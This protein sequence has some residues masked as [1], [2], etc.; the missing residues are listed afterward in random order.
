[1]YNGRD[2][3]ASAPDRGWLASKTPFMNNCWVVPS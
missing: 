3:V 2:P 1:M